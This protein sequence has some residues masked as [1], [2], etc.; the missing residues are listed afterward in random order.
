LEFNPSKLRDDA[1][2]NL[3]GSGARP[4][5]RAELDASSTDLSVKQEQD[6]DEDSDDLVIPAPP[7]MKDLGAELA[8]LEQ[9]EGT[10]LVESLRE[11]QEADLSTARGTSALRIQYASLLL[12]RLQFQNL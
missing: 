6:S 10:S 2:L 5:S 12:L 1:A 8:Q 11:Q 4:V 3:E 9:D 7:E